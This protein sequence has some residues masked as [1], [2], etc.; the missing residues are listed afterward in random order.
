MLQLTFLFIAML[1]KAKG[2]FFLDFLQFRPK[3]GELERATE[4]GRVGMSGFLAVIQ[5]SGP[6][7]LVS[8]T[9]KT[10]SNFDFNLLVLTVTPSK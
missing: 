9:Q 1:D 7:V 2:Y 10:F 4:I 6:G 3:S 8:F 5:S